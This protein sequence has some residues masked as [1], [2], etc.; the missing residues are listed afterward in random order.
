MSYF[1]YSDDFSF[2]GHDPLFTFDHGLR[3]DYLSQLNSIRALFWRQH[4]ADAQLQ[5][6][7]ERMEGIARSS[8]GEANDLAVDQHIELIHNSIYQDAAHSMAA[9]GMVAPLLESIFKHV[10]EQLG[11]KK[12]ERWLAK[13]IM[14]MVNDESLGMREYMPKDL[15]L[16]LDALFL[17]RNKMFH[18]GLEWPQTQRKAFADRLSDWPEGWFSSSTSDGEPWMFYMSGEFISHCLDTVEDVLRGLIRFQ[19]GPGR[20]I[21]RYPWEVSDSTDTL[22]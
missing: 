11:R 9:V 12:P 6:Q 19:L 22:V 8:I 18:H 7:I 16:T 2:D 14:E 21:W 17:Y 3:H 15:K 1:G 13:K 5:A 20:E 10:F 4:H